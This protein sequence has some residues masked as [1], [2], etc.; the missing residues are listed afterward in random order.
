MQVILKEGPAASA[1]AVDL[2]G[3]GPAGPAGAGLVTDLLGDDKPV[4]AGP[5]I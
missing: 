2:L 3:E 1:P 5:R 4:R